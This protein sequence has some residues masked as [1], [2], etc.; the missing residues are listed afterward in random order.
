MAMCEAVSVK[1]AWM[2]RPLQTTY[3]LFH[4]CVLIHLSNVKVYAFVQISWKM[5]KGTK[6]KGNLG[7]G[8]R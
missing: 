4:V 5:Y 6:K 2:R 1:D 8:K 3:A 7:R